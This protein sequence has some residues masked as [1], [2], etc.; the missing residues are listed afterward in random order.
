MF[1]TTPMSLLFGWRMADFSSSDNDNQPFTL[2]RTQGMSFSW[3]AFQ[4]AAM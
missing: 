4:S 2:A 3:Q 1:R